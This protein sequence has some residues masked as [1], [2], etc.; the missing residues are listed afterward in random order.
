MKNVIR[1]MDST[2]AS[3]SVVSSS[4]PS[5][6]LQMSEDQ[7]EL[8]DTIRSVL[9]AN[10]SNKLTGLTIEQQKK[11]PITGRVPTVDALVRI[12][13]PALVDAVPSQGAYLELHDSV[14]EPLLNKKPR[15]VLEHL[16]VHLLAGERKYTSKRGGYRQELDDAKQCTIKTSGPSGSDFGC[17]KCE[18]RARI[19]ANRLAFSKGHYAHD[20]ASDD[21]N[22]KLLTEKSA[23][24]V[25]YKIETEN[26]VPLTGFSGPVSRIR[27]YVF[28]EA[29][30]W[31]DAVDVSR[32]RIPA[33]VWIN[34]RVSAPSGGEYGERRGID[35]FLTRRDR[36]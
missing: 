27:D 28:R 20:S 11:D 18:C 13:V 10:V 19:L 31:M 3:F 36:V 29:W 15:D 32:R 24:D 16:L 2:G 22:A 9:M 4:P 33:C 26:F 14:T 7:K 6:G 1:L 21:E 34:V 12:A 25:L 8:A 17:K 5:V 23:R 35:G 30:Q